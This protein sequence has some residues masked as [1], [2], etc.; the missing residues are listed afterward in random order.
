QV[1]DRAGD[2]CEYCGHPAYAC[3]PFVC[4]HVL[5][6]VQGAGHSLAELAWSCL[7]CNGYKYAKTKSRD[8][9]T[10]RTVPLSNR[11]RERWERYFL[12]SGDSLLIVGRTATG[13]ATVA[14]LHSNRPERVNLRRA[15][16]GGRTSAQRALK[17]EATRADRPGTVSQNTPI[18][19]PAL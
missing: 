12:W 11:R 18:P 15:G 13:R 7:A 6:Q 14:A 9:Q 8:P 10:N 1:R 17:G 16:G 2:R 19:F 3:A 5:P 4:E